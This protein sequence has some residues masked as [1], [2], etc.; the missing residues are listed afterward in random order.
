MS[1]QQKKRKQQPEQ[2]IANVPGQL[3]TGMPSRDNI[4]KVVDFVSPQ[5][6]KYQILRT[7]EKDAYDPPAAPKKKQRTKP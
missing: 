3:N 6:A 7:T 5:G 1:T 2:P 4:R